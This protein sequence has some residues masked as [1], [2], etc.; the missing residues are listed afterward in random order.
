MVLEWIYVEP[1]ERNYRN[2]KKTK[3]AKLQH[4]SFCGQLNSD[5]NT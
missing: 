1:K 3:G 5:R 4:G 2:E